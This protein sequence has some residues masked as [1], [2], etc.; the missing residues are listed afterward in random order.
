MGGNGGICQV[1]NPMCSV[2]PTTVN[3]QFSFFGVNGHPDKRSNIC[4]M[5]Q[6]IMNQ[7][8]YLVLWIWFVILFGVSA[9]MFTYRIATF[10]LPAFR[11]TTILRQM[12]TNTSL[13]VDDLYLDFEHIGNWFLLSQ[14]GQNA[15]PYKFREFLKEARKL[16]DSKKKCSKTRK[17]RFG[18]QSDIG[19]DISNN[20]QM[21]LMNR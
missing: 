1:L 4:I 19:K 8:I 14:I 11:R 15:N 6:N 10:T 9:T 17:F 2:F 13:A 3:C 7:K 16:E 20:G 12:K 5:G 18:S 21:E